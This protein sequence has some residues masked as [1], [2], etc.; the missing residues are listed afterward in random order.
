MSNKI[1]AFFREDLGKGASRRLRRQNMVPGIVYGGKRKPVGIAMDFNKI[2]NILADETMFSSVL[3]LQVEDKTQ[4]VVIKDLQR[5]PAKQ[6]ISHIDFQRIDTKQTLTMRVPL[7]YIG[8]KNC[9]AIRMGAIMNQFIIDVEVSCL[10][11]DL[12]ESIDVDISNLELDESLKLSDIKLPKGVTILAFTHGDDESYDQTIVAIAKPKLME[13]I[14]EDIETE[15]GVED[16]EGGE[17]PEGESE[18]KN[19]ESDSESK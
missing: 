1:K 2:S 8:E 16:E 19:E 9:E 12:P 4:K 3:E 10:P 15:E 14:E 17:T 6:I 13:E 11:K 5:H 7:N 18:D